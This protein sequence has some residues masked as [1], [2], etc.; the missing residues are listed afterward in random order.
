MHIMLL[1]FI[2]Q[3]K[4][5]KERKRVTVDI[6]GNVLEGWSIWQC[7]MLIYIFFFLSGH[8][9]NYWLKNIASNCYIDNEGE[10]TRKIS[11]EH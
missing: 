7:N 9:E 1:Y 5:W 4:K 2:I 6:V 11:F 3:K 8:V 10:K